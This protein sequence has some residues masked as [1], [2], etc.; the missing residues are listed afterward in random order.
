MSGEAEQWR[1][2]SVRAA[3]QPAHTPV[4]AV[5]HLRRPR[6]PAAKP[7]DGTTPIS[8]G[9]NQAGQLRVQCV[10]ACPTNYYTIPCGGYCGLNA[11]VACP[12]DPTRIQGDVAACEDLQRV[13][14]FVTLQSAT[15]WGSWGGYNVWCALPRV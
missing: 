1:R 2:R 10:A 9:L 4:P 11:D 7:A 15:S 3:L 8:S 13:A 12:P 5:G 14:G 6:A